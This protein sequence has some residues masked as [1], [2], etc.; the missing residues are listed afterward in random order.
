MLSP[1]GVLLTA[2]GLTKL[3][4]GALP[5]R[6]VAPQRVPVVSG[7]FLLIRNDVWRQV[8]GFDERFFMYAEEVDLCARV[9]QLG[10]EI[11]CDPTIIMIHDA[12]S[13]AP[14]SASRRCNLLRGNATF[15][16]KHHGPIAAECACCFMLLHEVIRLIY[17]H[18]LLRLRDAPRSEMLRRRCREVLN[19]RGT[20]WMGWPVGMRFE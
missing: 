9:M 6:A 7:A 16:R 2:I 8:G 17:A 1:C 11:W 15:M 13:G 3:R 18:T 19:A 5:Y 12:G 10:Y 20:W 14:E 4:G